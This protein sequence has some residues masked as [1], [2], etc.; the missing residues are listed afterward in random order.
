M[1]VFIDLGSHFGA[2]TRKF[3]SSKLYSSDFVI[4]CFEANPVITPEIF[5]AY[6]AGCI[7]HREAAWTED[8]EIEF[9]IN[10]DQRVQGSSVF[11]E[12]VTG[13]LDKEHP[14][15]VPCIDFS[16]WLKKNFNRTDNVIVKSNIEGAEY[17]LFTKMIENGTI[18]M[19]S[20]LYLRR[21]W[22][23]IG[24]PREEDA[25]FMERLLA[26]GCPQ[27]FSDYDFDGVKA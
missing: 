8:G 22:H 1:N 2:I 25:C 26:G 14:V 11:K 17:P 16:A 9:F 18:D 3:M 27:V 21:H 5:A 23:K 13:N 12:K 10:H 6:P 20:K 4:H 19:I 15:K 24:M 7:I